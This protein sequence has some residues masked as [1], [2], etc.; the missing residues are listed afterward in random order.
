MYSTPHGPV[1]SILATSPPIKVSLF[2]SKSA[3]DHL[4]SIF[5]KSLPER[6]ILPRI[7]LGDATPRIRHTTQTMFYPRPHGPC[8]TQVS[9][10]PSPNPVLSPPFCFRLGARSPC[11]ILACGNLLC[12]TRLHCGW[13]PHYLFPGYVLKCLHFFLLLIYTC[14]VPFFGKKLYHFNCRCKCIHFS[15]PALLFNQQ[16]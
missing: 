13:R 11:A 4:I 6:K 3:T 1:C 10:F 9:P 15:V 7:P 2:N 5:S 12:P 14:I 16:I 8:Y